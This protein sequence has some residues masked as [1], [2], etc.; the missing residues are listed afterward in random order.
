MGF[1]KRSIAGLT[2]LAV[3]VCSFADFDGAAPVAWRFIESTKAVPGGVPIEKDGVVYI[4]LGGRV[5]ALDKAT[6]NLKWRY[7]AGEPLQANFRSG[8]TLA[9]G[10]VIAANDNRVM[11][12]LNASDGELAWQYNG[13][14]LI[15]GTPVVAQNYVVVPTGSSLM[16]VNL[17]DGAQA[18][19]NPLVYKDRF[20]SRLAAWNNLVIFPT[21]DSELVA[22]DV[23]TQKE[24]WS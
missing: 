15:T 22:V 19:A 20:Y 12:A 11:V 4:A 1:A 7:P 5:Y 16:A 3:G 18:W 10:K 21:V 9:G 14:D 17:S 24:K 2:I 13:A 6:G 8:V 23:E